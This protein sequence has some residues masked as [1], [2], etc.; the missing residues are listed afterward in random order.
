MTGRNLRNR[1]IRVVAYA[2]VST[3][4]EDQ[5]QSFQAQQE[6]YLQKF[7]ELGY[8]IAPTGLLHRRRGK[9]QVIEGIYADEGISATST[10]N[11][12]AFLRMIE[13]AKKGLFDMIFVK[14]T[15][16]FARNT[17]DGLSY[18][19]EL[20][21]VGV[22]VLF[23]DYNVCSISEDKDFEL[24]LFFSLAQ[25]ES[26]TK[27]YNVKWGIRRSQ[28]M[29]T[30]VTQASFGYDKVGR[31]LVINEAEA[32]IVREIFSIYLDEG[33][34]F[35]K[36]ATHLHA[37]GVPTKRGGKWHMRRIAEILAN[38]VYKGELRVH[39]LENRTIKDHSDKIQIPEEE[40]I[41]SY[42][43]DLRIISDEMWEKAQE[44]KALRS[45]QKISGSKPSRKYKYSSFLYCWGCGSTYRA[46]RI[47]RHK[48]DPIKYEDIPLE[49]CCCARDAYRKG[50][51][52]PTERRIKIRESRIDEIVAEQIIKIKQD[53]SYLDTLFSVYELVTRGIPKTEEEK[54]ELY[55]RRE[56]INTE[57]RLVL[58]RAMDKDTSVYDE[59]LDELE[60]ELKTVN[61]EISREETRHKAVEADLA[62][63]HR[64]LDKLNS[65]DPYNFSRLELQD[66]FSRV[67]VLELE[68]DLTGWN[69]G[70]ATGLIFEYKFIDIPQMELISRACEMHIPFLE[71]EEIVI[72]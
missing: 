50:V 3:G 23:E 18:C 49:Y 5:K 40:Q 7:R 34:G 46:K 70:E 72:V 26:Q 37:K 32:E 19:E 11:R 52:C 51:F 66:L 25:K 27:S 68:R 12:V 17:V 21:K 55:K 29:G 63:Y 39:T 58:K 48:Q 2:R 16:R 53:K 30:W 22:S 67:E 59:I 33:W 36:I 14:S 9:D 61:G 24:S 71:M 28:Q 43:E 69:K 64:Y 20:R 62:K 45:S 13:D 65:I 31:D 56:E 57:I 15:S 8:T 41:V 44:Q 1:N 10:K 54:A 42:R 47:W 38:P 60:N 4:S 6:Y 35:S